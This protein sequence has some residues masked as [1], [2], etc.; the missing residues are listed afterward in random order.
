MNQPLPYEI[1]IAEKLEQL[2]VPD[3]VDAIWAR[4]EKQLDAELPEDDGPGEPPASPGSGPGWS[5]LGGSLFTG[6][7][8]WVL[9]NFYHPAPL[10]EPAPVSTAVPETILP[11]Q[12]IIHP[13]ESPPKKTNHQSPGIFAAPPTVPSE[14]KPD[15]TASPVDQPLPE[16]NAILPEAIVQEPEKKTST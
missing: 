14:N 3:M 15:A 10:P 4:I 12:P 8:V 11:D 7:I 6:I 13:P 5:F 2:S 9:L 1:A 16:N